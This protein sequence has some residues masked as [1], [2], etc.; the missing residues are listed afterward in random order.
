MPE[1]K[2]IS[3]QVNANGSVGIEGSFNSNRTGTGLYTVNF[4]NNVFT[5]EPIIVVTVITD[6]ESSTYTAC[7]SIHDAS[8]NGFSL[9]VQNL[10]GKSKDFPFNFIA[11]SAQ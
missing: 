9:S 2:T 1:V 11:T 4:N 3:G 7:A 5:S 10:S 6:G 8:P